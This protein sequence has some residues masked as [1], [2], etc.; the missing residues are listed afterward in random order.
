[1]ALTGFTIIAAGFAVGLLT[2]A[3]WLGLSGWFGLAWMVCA[4]CFTAV[5]TCVIALGRPGPF[6]ATA[7]AAA[8]F[9]AGSAAGAWLITVLMTVV[10]WMFA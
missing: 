5:G 1:V 9:P 7:A 4:C 6:A 3:A 2:S 8:A 10:L